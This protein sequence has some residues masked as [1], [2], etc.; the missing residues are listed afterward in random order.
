MSKE[1]AVFLDRDGVINQLVIN[2]VIGE[3]ESPHRVEDLV[4]YPYAAKSLRRLQQNNYLL[5]LVSNQPSYAKGKTTFENILAVHEAIND[6]MVKNSIRFAEF[7]YCYHHPKGIVP[8]YSF[9]CPCRKPSPYFLQKAKQ[10]YDLDMAGSWFVGD[11]DTD[12]LCGQ[13]GGVQTIL[14]SNE[15]SSHKRGA[16]YPDYKAENLLAAVELLLK[17]NNE[18]VLKGC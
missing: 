17:Y 5:F 10:E 1:R 3:Y 8:E 9:V 11:Q 2:S 18:N 13:A 4:I 7:Y 15:H 16:S 6:Y 14:L 12:V